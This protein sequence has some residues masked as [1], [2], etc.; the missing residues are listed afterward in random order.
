ML[1]GV[2]QILREA[3]GAQAHLYALVAFVIIDFVVAGFVLAK[4]SKT[5]FTSA[6]AWS[7]IRIV[8]QAA[9]VSQA[10]VFDL[11]YSDFANYLFNPLLTTSPNPPGVPGAIIDLIVL[12]EFIVVYV[13]W[14]ARSSSQ[15]KS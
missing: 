12:L 15:T 1:L 7:L 4:G 8:L 13:A 3:A 11:S 9:D 14:S 10:N 5:A 6:A 2:D